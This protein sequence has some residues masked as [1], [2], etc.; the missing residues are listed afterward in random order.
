[1]AMRHLTG[2]S[3][4]FAPCAIAGALRL[5]KVSLRCIAAKSVAGN[6]GSR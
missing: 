5:V 6:T 4:Y 3:M 1:M 2:R